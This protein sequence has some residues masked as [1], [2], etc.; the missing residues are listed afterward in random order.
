M[1]GLVIYAGLLALALVLFLLLPQIDLA[2][3]GLFYSAGGGFVLVDWPPVVF[4][5][6]AIPRITWLLFALVAG[7]AIWLFLMERPLWRL[8]R[9]ALIFLV[10]STAL[11][12]GLL[13]NALLKDH[14]GRARPVQIEEFGGP[15]QF[16]PAP[17]P[18]GECSANCAFVSGHA[19]LG[20]S[21]VAFAF[22]FPPG[23][24]NGATAAAL[25]LGALVGLG[26]IAQGA[27]FVSDVVYAGLLVYGTT[28]VLY[29]WIIK[30]DGL[31]APALVRLY[32]A[33]GRGAAAT[34]RVGRRACAAPAFGLALGSIV[35]VVLIVISIEHVDRPLALFLH[36][37]DPDLR[38][39]FD[40]IGRLGLTY[41]YLTVFG[42]AFV[43]LHWGGLLPRLERFSLPMRAFSAIPAFLFLSVAASGL[44][45]DLLKFL[46][47]RPRPKL[48]FGSGVFDFGWLGL[49]AD[50]W[51]FP[52]GHAATIVALAAALC[53]LWPRHLL[54]YVLV[55][56]IVSLSRVIVGAHYLSDILAGAL[57]AVLTTCC[58]ALIFAKGGIDLAPARGGI[59]CPRLPWPCRRFGGVFGEQRPRSRES[60]PTA[61]AAHEGCS[62]GANL[63]R[64]SPI[65]SPSWPYASRRSTTSAAGTPSTRR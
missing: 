56:G 51:S 40:L 8:D 17:L 26:R 11:G 3:S 36:S 16:T 4:L 13:A 18:A 47:G 37:R 14:W 50:Y 23:L 62:I 21:L 38:A 54:F 61:C 39:L 27:H 52:S 48:L 55:A 63:A 31:A 19:A 49:R 60:A 35:M 33:F 32:R 25:G 6:Q 1:R 20:F 41:G 10:A 22:L 5:Y 9:K 59:R 65:D 30:R 46:F 57:T 44:V 28:A 43:A 64:G 24:R 12:P 29:W 15:R 34:W 45:A 42:L 53:Y 58:M 7:A 2:T